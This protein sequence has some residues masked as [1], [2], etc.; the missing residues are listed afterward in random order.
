MGT[1][2]AHITSAVLSGIAA[3]RSMR[4]RSAGCAGAWPCIW[5]ELAGF[6]SLA[7]SCARGILVLACFARCAQ[8]ASWPRISSITYAVCYGCLSWRRGCLLHGTQAALATLALYFAAGNSLHM[9][10]LSPSYPD[11]QIQLPKAG[12]PAGD[13]EFEGHDVHVQELR[14]SEYVPLAH[15]LQGAGPTSILYMPLAHASHASPLGPENP[16]LH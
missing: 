13:V 11:V 7:V 8:A 12:L 5:L 4:V 16:W 9:V 3:G 15:A 6:A 1:R 14:P 10:A 2:V